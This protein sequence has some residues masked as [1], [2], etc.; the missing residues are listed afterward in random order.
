MRTSKTVIV[1]LLRLE[2]QEL[3][4]IM[5]LTKLQAA[6]TKAKQ[7]ACSAQVPCTSYLQC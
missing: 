1:E 4:R 2:L 6:V 5:I 7:L 3:C